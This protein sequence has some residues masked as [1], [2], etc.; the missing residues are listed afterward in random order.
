MVGQNGQKVKYFKLVVFCGGRLQGGK[1]FA[2]LQMDVPQLT[3][4]FKA[5]AGRNA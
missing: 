3:F 4:R 1:L 5:P 2:D